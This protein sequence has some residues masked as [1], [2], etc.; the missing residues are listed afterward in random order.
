LSGEAASGP[1][2]KASMPWTMRS[3][4]APSAWVRVCKSPARQLP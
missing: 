1:R 4:R 3:S 2:K